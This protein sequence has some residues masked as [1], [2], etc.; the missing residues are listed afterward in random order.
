MSRPTTAHDMPRV[1]SLFGDCHGGWQLDKNEPPPCSS[2]Y[3]SPS[4]YLRVVVIG[5]GAVQT[6]S[7]R[8][9]L[10]FRKDMRSQ[11]LISLFLRS[12]R[13]GEIRVRVSLQGLARILCQHA[14]MQRSVYT[15]THTPDVFFGNDS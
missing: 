13:V 12:Y 9:S 2:C 10:G 4:P 7:R 8:R 5:P 3:A 11:D 14:Q 6:I 1:E 15:Y